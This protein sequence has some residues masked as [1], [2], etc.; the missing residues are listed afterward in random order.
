MAGSLGSDLSY[1]DKRLEK[2]CKGMFSGS[3]SIADQASQAVIHVINILT[4]LFTLFAYLPL[5][6]GRR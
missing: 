4:K 2:H 5:N 1:A 3:T 6:T